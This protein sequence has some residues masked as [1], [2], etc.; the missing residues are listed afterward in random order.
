M[1]DER[2]CF[3]V[4]RRRH[5]PHP[6]PATSVGKFAFISRDAKTLIRM[7]S[8]RSKYGSLAVFELFRCV[9]DILA[10]AVFISNGANMKTYWIN[11]NY[12]RI[13]PD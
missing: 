12:W 9:T 2:T 13:L 1:D 10:V 7:D 6:H 4:E 3:V 8:P 5:L 11:Y